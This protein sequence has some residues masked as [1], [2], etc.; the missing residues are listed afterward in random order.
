MFY[1]YKLGRDSLSLSVKLPMS[2]ELR[3][4]AASA[5]DRYY[6][7][8]MWQQGPS[9]TSP[10]FA[11]GGHPAAMLG[12]KYMKHRKTLRK[13]NSGSLQTKCLALSTDITACYF[14]QLRVEGALCESDQPSKAKLLGDRPPEY[15]VVSEI[16]KWVSDIGHRMPTISVSGR[17]LRSHGMKG[18]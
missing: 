9:Q 3:A 12:N 6:S 8:L 16:A 10:C 14:M 2:L 4:P 17:L 7:C 15:S 1:I 11:H 18:C 13:T 5:A